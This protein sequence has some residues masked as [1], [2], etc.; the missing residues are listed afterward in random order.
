MICAVD[1]RPEAPARR[2]LKTTG[3]DAP[4]TKRGGARKGAGRKP[5][6]P[7]FPNGS[8]ELVKTINAAI[9]KIGDDDPAVRECIEFELRVMRGER[10]YAGRHI[11]S[12]VR[13]ARDLLDRMLGK[14]KQ[15]IEMGGG[16]G[17]TLEDM[18]KR[19][20]DGRA[21]GPSAPASS[22]PGNEEGGDGE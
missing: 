14:P 9:K 16:L 12:R 22:S 1:D 15:Q 8:L 2:R 4:K 13:T 7:P 18:V 3:R 5:G 20:Y 11:G 21:P 17:L 19:S 10:G 6:P